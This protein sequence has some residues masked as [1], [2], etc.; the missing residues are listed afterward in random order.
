MKTSTISN[1]TKLRTGKVSL[2][3]K[4]EPTVPEKQRLDNSFFWTPMTWTN[5]R[6]QRTWT[7][8]TKANEVEVTDST[9]DT[10]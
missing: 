1:N 6:E 5:T 7:D 8:V 9:R 10:N 4:K 3:Q 2:I